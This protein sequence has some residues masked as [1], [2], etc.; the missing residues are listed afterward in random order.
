MQSAL[1][2][3]IFRR[4]RGAKRRS[5]LTFNKVRP[6][7]PQKITHPIS[8]VSISVREIVVRVLKAP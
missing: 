3:M 6:Y 5:M 2:I 7:G 4:V 8:K 1:L